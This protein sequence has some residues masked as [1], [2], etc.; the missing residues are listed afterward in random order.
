MNCQDFETQIALY[1]G[2]DLIEKESR[3]VEK[4]LAECKMCKEFMVDLQDSQL[5]LTKFSNLDINEQIFVDLRAS[6]LQQITIEKQK[7]SWW[8]DFFSFKLRFIHYATAFSVLVMFTTILGMILIITTGKNSNNALNSSINKMQST[9]LTDKT[10]KLLANNN[11]N[12]IKEK[13]KLTNNNVKDEKSIVR[14]INYLNAKKHSIKINKN[15]IIAIQNNTIDIQNDKKEPIKMEIQTKNPNIRII[16]F[17][18]QDEKHTDK[19]T[20]S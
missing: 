8:K 2:N 6:V 3:V 1:V 14:H 4:H 12:S 20:N 11:N 9:N 16:W 17:T 5:A 10:Q 18:N 15:N 13:D 19:Q 7:T